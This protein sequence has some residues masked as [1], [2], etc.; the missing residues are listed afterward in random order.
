MDNRPIYDIDYGKHNGKVSLHI[1][2]YQNGIKQPT[3]Y[4]VPK[5]LI[6]KYIKTFKGVPKKWLK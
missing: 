3:A 5:V 1:H 2:Y 6:N 4:E